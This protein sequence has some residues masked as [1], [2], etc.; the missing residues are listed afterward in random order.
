[1]FYND[2]YDCYSSLNIQPGKHNEVWTHGL[3]GV[4]NWIQK[5]FYL[6]DSLPA[7]D[8]T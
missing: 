1:M 3:Q 5:H 4:S 7:K 6:M 8:E 2:I